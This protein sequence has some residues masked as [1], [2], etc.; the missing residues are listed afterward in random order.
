MFVG[1][2]SVLVSGCTTVPQAPKD[3]TEMAAF[4]EDNLLNVPVNISG[5]LASKVN[6]VS[7]EDKTACVGLF[8]KAFGR[9]GDSGR[10]TVFTDPVTRKIYDEDG[11][12]V[13][14]Q[15][16]RV[17][18]NGYVCK[19]RIIGLNRRVYS[20]DENLQNNCRTSRAAKSRDSNQMTAIVGA[21]AAGA[22]GAIVTAVGVT[23]LDVVTAD[24]TM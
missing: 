7:Q 24:D 17:L 21:L 14:E 8:C 23:T 5:F 20:N 3:A 2:L 6:I 18:K 4:G 13:N 16:E 19:V 15:A 9:D 22:V 11:Q 1:A 12:P 10:V